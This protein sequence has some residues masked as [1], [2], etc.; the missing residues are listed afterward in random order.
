MKILDTYKTLMLPIIDSEFHQVTQN[1]TNISTTQKYAS[2]EDNDPIE[3]PS[4]LYIE[5]LKP[6]PKT[7][8]SHLLL[9]TKTSGDTERKSKQIKAKCKLKHIKMNTNR[10]KKNEKTFNT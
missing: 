1:Q 3:T 4:L 8:T 7:K 10:E 2:R 5:K 6:E 9:S